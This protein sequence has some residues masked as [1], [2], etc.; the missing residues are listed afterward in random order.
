M[1]FGFLGI[2]DRIREYL[3]AKS[4]VTCKV[5]LCS[6][7]L[8]CKLPPNRGQSNL[9]ILHTRIIINSY[10]NLNPVI[11]VCEFSSVWKSHLKLECFI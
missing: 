10:Q 5:Q 4:H 9:R 8:S 6:A 11:G 2:F 3:T 1:S 7:T